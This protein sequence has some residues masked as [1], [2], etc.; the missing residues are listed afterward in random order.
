M[1]FTLLWA[2]SEVLEDGESLYGFAFKGWASLTRSAIALSN[3]FVQHTDFDAVVI[4]FFYVLVAAIL[5][6]SIFE[7]CMSW[8]KSVSSGYP[9]IA[10]RRAIRL[11]FA[12]RVG[13]APAYDLAGVDVCHEVKIGAIIFEE[14]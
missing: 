2:S 7:W 8:W 11:Y 3:G 9:S 4:E 6:S 10:I 1:V 14:M 13:E 12:S 5:D